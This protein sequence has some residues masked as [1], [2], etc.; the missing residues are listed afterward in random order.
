MEGNGTEGESIRGDTVA[1]RVRLFLG[2][3]HFP[4]LCRLRVSEEEGTVTLEGEVS[5]YYERQVAVECTRH[6]PGVLGIVDQITVLK[7]S[8]FSV[9]ARQ[10]G[11][12]GLASNK[13]LP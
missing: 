10:S 3:R 1:E 11:G 7:P 9:V 13:R 2:G 12:L 6:V 4:A 8:P 5:S